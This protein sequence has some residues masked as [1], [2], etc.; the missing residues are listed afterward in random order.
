MKEKLAIGAA[1][2]LIGVGA[3]SMTA[4]SVRAQPGPPCT[5]TNHCVDITVAGGAIPPVANVVVPGKNHQIY[6]QI[7]TGG[8]SFPSPPHSAG[9]AFKAP[10]PINNNG[11]MPANEFACNRVSA[12]RFHCT[13]TNSTHG[14]GVRTYQYA[15]TVVDTSGR[16]IVSDPWIIN[17]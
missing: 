16:T 5:G 14:A 17:R 8:Y 7:K 13:D 3:G 11:K 4:T 12:T 9:I 2:I 15:I 1:S 10:S 6:W